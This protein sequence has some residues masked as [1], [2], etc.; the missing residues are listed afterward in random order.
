[1]MSFT[2]GVVMLPRLLSKD[3]STHER[4]GV[5]LGLLFW[6]AYSTAAAVVQGHAFTNVAVGILIPPTLQ[7][8][9]LNLI[10]CALLLIGARPA[11]RA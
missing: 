6:A 8:M 4:L 5:L 7:V 2:F 3:S 10:D 9:L 11:S 1:M